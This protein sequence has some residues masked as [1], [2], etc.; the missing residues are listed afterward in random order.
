MTLRAQL[1]T[2]WPWPVA[3][4]L[5]V[6]ASDRLA[7]SVATTGTF[8]QSALPT[9]ALSSTRSFTDAHRTFA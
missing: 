5:C 3:Q 1:E 6:S 4:V 7:R 8:R 2:G 9:K